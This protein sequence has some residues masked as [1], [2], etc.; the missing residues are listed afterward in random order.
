MHTN[1]VFNNLFIVYHSL[2]FDYGTKDI[3]LKMI[4]PTHVVFSILHV[5]KMKFQIQSQKLPC[6]DCRIHIVCIKFST[7]LVTLY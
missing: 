5:Q 3:H 6:W 2:S 7:H 1:E 4:F